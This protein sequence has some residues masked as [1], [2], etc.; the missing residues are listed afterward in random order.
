MP[1]KW[2]NVRRVDSG[3]CHGPPLI[4]ILWP[5]PPVTLTDSQLDEY[6]DRGYLLVPELLSVA[7]VCCLREVLPDILARP[8]PEVV[9]EKDDAS[10]AR[11]AFGAHL[12]AEPFAALARLPKVLGPSQNLVGE[13]V[14]LHQ[15][16]INPKEG[17][18]PSS[19]WEWHQDYPPWHVVD[20]MPEPRCV[21]TSVFLDDCTPATSPLLVVPGSHGHGLIDSY[22]PHPEARGALLYHLGRDTVT[23]LAEENGI[24]PLL[25][26][27]GSVAFVNCNLVHGSANNVSPWRR[28]I[29]YLIYNACSNGCTSEERL[30]FQNERDFTPLELVNEATL[31]E[32]AS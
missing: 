31:A 23:A 29:A 9:R 21:M 16:R 6:R 28:A 1:T 11:L 30:W 12:Y 32:L 26:P 2:A 22:R 8:G 17:F 5:G 10:S 15:S 4:D 24:E 25:G 27:A 18:A 3:G 7:E 14:Y 13:Q 19:G 20:G